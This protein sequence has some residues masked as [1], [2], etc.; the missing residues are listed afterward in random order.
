[1]KFLRDVFAIVLS[2]YAI[3]I[4]GVWLSYIEEARQF[5]RDPGTQNDR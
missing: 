4:V 3:I 1:M 5:E 2:I